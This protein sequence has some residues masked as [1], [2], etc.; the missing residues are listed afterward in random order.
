VF[1]LTAT[2]GAMTRCYPMP[3][4]FCKELSQPGIFLEAKEEAKESENCED[5]YNPGSK[6]H[7]S[8]QKFNVSLS[9]A[10]Q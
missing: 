10:S 2:S 9:C 6:I 3:R 5:E 7:F 4:T 8:L 1:A